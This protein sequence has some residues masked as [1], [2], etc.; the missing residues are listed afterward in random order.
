[1]K[2]DLDLLEDPSDA[3]AT[4]ESEPQRE[5]S[6]A[7]LELSGLL[8]LSEI[9]DHPSGAESDEAAPDPSELQ[10]EDSSAALELSW[11]LPT[12]EIEGYPFSSEPKQDHASVV[13]QVPASEELALEGQPDDDFVIVEDLSVERDLVTFDLEGDTPAG[14]IG[15]RTIEK[16]EGIRESN[17][18]Q[19]AQVTDLDTKLNLA[20]AYIELGDAKNAKPM[21]QEVIKAGTEQQQIDAR[22]L[23]DQLQSQPA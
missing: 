21:L 16:A 12:R 17:L 19:E 9:N 13:D 2:P 3:E 14:A 5:D 18:E 10:R 6:S 22:H 4:P 1:M 8:P 7:E 15:N 11:L 20:K 23:L